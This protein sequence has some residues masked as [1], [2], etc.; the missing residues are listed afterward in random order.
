M[1]TAT[2]FFDFGAS[3]ETIHNCFS[4]LERALRGET[5]A[6]K[7][8]RGTAKFKGARPFSQRD[9]KKRA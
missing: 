6:Q 9:R 7:V 4:L 1:T 5:R 8:Y 3:S 2:G